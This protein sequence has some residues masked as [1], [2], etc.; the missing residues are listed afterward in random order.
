ME[1]R[2]TRWRRGR[3]DQRLYR[4]LGQTHRLGSEELELLTA[5]ADHHRLVRLSEI[6]VRP[7]LFNG[8]P[9]PSRWGPR[10]VRALR[11][12]I[13]RSGEKEIEPGRERKKGVERRG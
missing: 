11:D 8:S 12:R 3:A 5:L 13:S 1:R 9:D 2:L 4:H 6:F 10:E 7:G